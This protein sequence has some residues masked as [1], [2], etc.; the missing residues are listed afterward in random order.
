MESTDRCMTSSWGV[1]VADWVRNTVMLTV[2]AIW[3][4][5]VAVTL[6]RGDDID[7]IVWGLPGAVYFALNPTWKKG[8]KD[9]PR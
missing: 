1:A 8:N 5:Y 2:M 7:A 4:V 9:G 6:I 3:S